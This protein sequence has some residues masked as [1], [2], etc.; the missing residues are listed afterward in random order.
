MTQNGQVSLPAAA[1]QVAGG[2]AVAGS[3]P[4][5]GAHS[6]AIRAEFALPG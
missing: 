6:A 2:D 3:V 4:A 1:V 5:L